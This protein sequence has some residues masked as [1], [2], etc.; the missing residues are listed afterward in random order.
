MH[1]LARAKSH[2]RK[3]PAAAKTHTPERTGAPGR[4]RRHANSNS[5]RGTPGGQQHQGG[6]GMNGHYPA[7]Q[8]EPATVFPPAVAPTQPAQPDAPAGDDHGHNGLHL[9]WQQ[10]VGHQHH[11]QDI[12]GTHVP[13]GQA[14]DPPTGDGDGSSGNDSGRGSH[15]N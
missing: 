2:A 5:Q 10:G 11:E 9:G 3:R 1:A 15:G 8:S 7:G 13:G 4:H 12:D 6:L 14:D